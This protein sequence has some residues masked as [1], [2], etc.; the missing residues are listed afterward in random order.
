M[1]KRITL[2]IISLFLAN[3]SLAAPQCTQSA[4][5]DCEVGCYIDLD[6]GCIPCKGEMYNNQTGQYFCSHCGP[7]STSNND[8]TGCTCKTGYHTAGQSQNHIKNNSVACEANTYRITYNQNVPNPAFEIEN[9]QYNG[10]FTTK[11]SDTFK[12]PAGYI[13]KNWTY[14]DR[15]FKPN[16]T[17]QYTYTTNITLYAQWSKCQAGYYCPD[18]AGQTKCPAGAT[19]DAGAD[20]ITDCYMSGD[21]Q[22]CD[23]DGK[24]IDLPTGTKIYANK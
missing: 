9:V 12:Y 24:C 15:E 18:G 5:T 17:Y 4:I 20:D 23:Q 21:T 16:F 1:K 7:N 13:F 11:S 22:I 14:N 6:Q 2:T 19:S 10:S 3:I 8:K